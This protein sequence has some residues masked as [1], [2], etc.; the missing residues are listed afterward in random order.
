M[1]KYKNNKFY[2]FNI[3]V[4]GG[5]RYSRQNKKRDEN[6]KYKK[7]ERCHPSVSFPL[8]SLHAH[9]DLQ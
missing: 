4:L 1:Y 6:C 7:L 3:Q 8:Q 9:I 5:K 2:N